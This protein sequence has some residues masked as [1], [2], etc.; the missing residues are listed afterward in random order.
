M[1]KDLVNIIIERQRP[2][3]K[4]NISVYEKKLSDENPIYILIN[5]KGDYFRLTQEGWFIWQQLDGNKSLQDLTKTY[6][7]EFKQS[8][9]EVVI[10]LIT[11]L[12]QEGF[13]DEQSGK[14]FK[15]KE[16]LSIWTKAI[17][18]VRQFLKSGS[19]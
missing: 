11:D 9:P 16:K 2:M 1:K 10:K 14:L 3:R 8:S 19:R 17:N 5:E 18:K 13:I 12:T 15:T 7:N 6:L 4:E